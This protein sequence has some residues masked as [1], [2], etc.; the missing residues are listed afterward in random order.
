MCGPQAQQL[1]KLC[2]HVRQLLLLLLPLL[3]TRRLLLLPLILLL[4]L[5][6]LCEALLVQLLLRAADRARAQHSRNEGAHCVP[7]C[8]L[9]RLLLCV[10]VVV[11][12]TACLLSAL[13]CSSRGCVGCWCGRRCCCCCCY[14]SWHRCCDLSGSAAVADQ[15]GLLLQLPQVC[16]L[17]E[18]VD[19]LLLPLLQRCLELVQ[20]FLLLCRLLCT[21]LCNQCGHCLS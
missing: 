20:V 19:V 12:L 10:A 16:E 7:S 3:G 15:R 2:L 8:T 13:A 14:H 17:P 5:L 4:L 6:L 18:Q 1:V 21:C 9:L 11:T